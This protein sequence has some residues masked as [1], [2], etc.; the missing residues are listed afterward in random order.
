MAICPYCETRTETALVAC[1]SGDGFFTIEETDWQ[2][3]R[4]EPLLGWPVAGR[5]IVTSLVGRGSMA[6]V[7]RARQMQLNRDVALKLFDS[8]ELQHEL[9]PQGDLQTAIDMAK[10]RFEREAQVL[11]KISHPNCVTLYDYGVSSDGRFLFIAM[12]F[13]QGLSLRQA[14]NRGLKFDAIVEIAQQVLLALREAHAL[15]IV[16]RDLKPENIIL[17]VR[18]GTEEQV[19]KV[20]DFGIAKMLSGVQES[21]TMAGTLF[22]TPAYMSPEQCRGETDTVTAASDIYALGC[23]LYELITGKLPFAANTPQEMVRMHLSE[24]PPRAVARSGIEVSP[25]FQEFLLK[26]MQKEPEKRYPDAHAALVALDE[27]VGLDGMGST[28]GYM[29][30]R[31][32]AS[33]SKAPRVSVPKDQIRGDQFAPP[34]PENVPAAPAVRQQQSQEPSLGITDTHPPGT[35]KPP[36]R[37]PLGAILLVGFLVVLAFCAALLYFIWFRI[38]G[39]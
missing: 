19:V 39:P 37:S 1:P 15:G 18:F 10:E 4:G 34:V 13:V 16:H 28:S 27:L 36:K 33:Q 2:T 14:V 29:R 11:A 9:M 7:F 38:V 35:L 17:S 21:R 24:P 26:C 20:V 32:A 31:A 8:A 30:R 23:V 5:F 25:A 22:G 12:E 3:C 6:R